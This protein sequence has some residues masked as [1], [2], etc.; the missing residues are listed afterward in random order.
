MRNMIEHLAE[1]HG[2]T[3]QN[4]DGK[5]SQAGF[6]I[7]EAF[8]RASHPCN[9][10]FNKKIFKQ[11]LIWC[12]I[13]SNISFLQVEIEA[14]RVLLAYLCACISFPFSKAIVNLIYISL[15]LNLLVKMS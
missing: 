6:Q 10:Q 15:K 7:E 1:D 9:I 2:I 4:E 5:I 14:F 12:I 3:K 8:R 11:L 13:I